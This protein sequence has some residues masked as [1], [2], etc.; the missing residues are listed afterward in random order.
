MALVFDLVISLD[1]SVKIE[2]HSAL[3]LIIVEL[4]K[5]ISMAGTAI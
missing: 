4:R 3:E 1:L 2:H 5:G